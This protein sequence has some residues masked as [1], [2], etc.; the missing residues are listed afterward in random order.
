MR[1]KILWASALGVAAVLIAGGILASNMGFK[2]NKLL[3]GPD[4]LGSTG[5]QLIALPF[6][7]QTNL[8]NAEG[9]ITDIGAGAVDVVARYVRSTDGLETYTGSA[10]VNFGLT[11]GDPIY[12]TVNTDTS[13]IAVGS[14]DPGLIVALQGP[15]GGSTGTNGYAYPYHSVASNAEQLINEIEAAVG[16]DVVDVVARYVKATDG[17]E[18]YTGSAGVNFNLTPGDGYLITVTTDLGF[19][20]AHY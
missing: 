15:A 4:G 14:H 8:T 3:N 16:G 10:G 18:T 20:P 5:T 7:Q 2:I 19:T 1:R 17:L 13:Y 6:N 12:V 9:V 11:A